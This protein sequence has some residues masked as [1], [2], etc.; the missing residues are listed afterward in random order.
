MSWRSRKTVAMSDGDCNSAG[1]EQAIKPYAGRGMLRFPGDP[2]HRLHGLPV[3]FSEQR[4]AKT[5]GSV[6]LVFVFR[7]HLLLGGGM[8]REVDCSRALGFRV[9]DHIP[10]PASPKASRL[11]RSKAI[12]NSCAK[13]RCPASISRFTSADGPRPHLFPKAGRRQSVLRTIRWPYGG[14]LPPGN[15]PKPPGF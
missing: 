15:L 11:Q 7:A 4:V 1:G 6:Q 8:T 9:R 2:A 3:S 12:P 14:P 13:G 5:I 10:L